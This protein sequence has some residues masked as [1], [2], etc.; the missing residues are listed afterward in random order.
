MQNLNQYAFNAAGEKITWA[1]WY[2]TIRGEKYVEPASKKNGYFCFDGS[3]TLQCVSA[4]HELYV[5]SHNAQRGAAIATAEG[6]AGEAPKHTP[7][8]NMGVRSSNVREVVELVIS[9]KGEIKEVPI[10]F[11]HGDDSSFIDWVNYTIH[12]ETALRYTSKLSGLDNDACAM[13]IS[14][15]LE[16]IFGF[17]ITIKRPSGSDF[18]KESFILG[19]NWGRLCIGGQ[20]DTIL[21]N[22]FGSGCTAAAQGWEKR[23]FTFLTEEAIQPK[24]TRVDLTFDDIEGALYSVDQAKQDHLDGKFTLKG[25][26]TPTG[27]CIGDW[28]RVNGRGRTKTVGS[29]GSGKYLRVYEKGMQLGHKFH[30]WVRIELEMKSTQLCIP[31]DVLLKAG[32]YLSA[33]YP[34]LNWISEEKA[35]R[36]KTAK[37]ELEVNVNK[38]I[39]IVRHQFGNHINALAQLFGADKILDLI[40]RNDKTPERLQVKDFKFAPLSLE[41]QEY[42]Y[43]DSDHIVDLLDVPQSEKQPKEATFKH[44]YDELLETWLPVHKA[45]FDDSHDYGL[46]EFQKRNGLGIYSAP[47]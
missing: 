9:D 15:R 29:R 45:D 4:S 2:A 40:V 35:D 6:G 11:G 36:P 39:E 44:Q 21:I 32:A 37:K 38:V 14:K 31:F 1:E 12:K 20:N 22:I 25:R 5:L 47:F 10:R 23:L 18:Y 17:A 13:A 41:K 26:R 27:E 19:D 16:Y 34:A 42:L 28:E 24:I 33:S 8:D 7:T 46:D 3:H 43:L 30:P